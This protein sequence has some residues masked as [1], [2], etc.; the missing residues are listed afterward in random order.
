MDIDK[1]KQGLTKHMVTPGFLSAIASLDG[2][3]FIDVMQLMPSLGL[4][5]SFA[6]LLLP[7]RLRCVMSYST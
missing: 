6:K 7:V 2:W 3:S 5:A 1:R 4:S